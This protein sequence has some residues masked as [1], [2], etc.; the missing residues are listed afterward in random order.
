MNFNNIIFSNCGVATNPWYLASYV[1]KHLIFY[2]LKGVFLRAVH[3]FTVAEIG[4]GWVKSQ[5]CVR[6]R[7]W[8]ENFANLSLRTHEKRHMTLNLSQISC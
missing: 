3:I 2:F 8:F 4:A 1:N 6:T 7:R 5:T